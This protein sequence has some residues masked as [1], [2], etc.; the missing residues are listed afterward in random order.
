MAEYDAIGDRY[1][2]AKR[3][4]WR[5]HLEA[6]TVE[7]LAGDVRG[8]RVL[9]LACGDGFYTRRFKALGAA[10][11]LGVDV[12]AEMIALARRAEADAPLGCRYAVADVNGLGALGAFDLVVAVYLLNYAQTADELHQLCAATYANLR[13]GGRL[14]GANDY[15]AD[16]VTGTRDFAGHGFHKRGP[17]AYVEG[18]P[19]TYE[20][21]LPEGRSFAITNYYWQ[22]ATYLQ[23]LRD[24]GYRDPTWHP[25][26][27]APQGSSFPRGHWDDFLA[28]GPCAAFAATRPAG[29]TRAPTR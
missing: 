15:T 26:E 8:A 5:I 10:E 23:T 9:D 16:A 12:S 14:I 18:Q 7:R 6:Y 13:P 11:V 2:E 21:L 17:A 19:I 27:L 3:A 28:S 20:F 22:P 1:S 25:F 4:P 29:G 24:A